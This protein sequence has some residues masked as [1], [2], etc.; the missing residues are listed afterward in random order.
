MS[1]II[2]GIDEAGRGPWAGPVIAACVILNKNIPGLT[3]SKKITAAKREKLFFEITANNIYSIAEA[4]VEEIDQLNILNATK[5]AISR[6]ISNLPEQADHYLIDGNMKFTNFSN[7]TSIV[8]GDL[9]EPSIS[10]ASIIAKVHRDNLMLQL[11][12]HYPE[13]NLASN[14][15]YGTKAHIEAVK[16][17]G[18]TAI[19]RKSFNFFKNDRFE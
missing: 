13:Y 16:K 12:E 15:G 19:H 5:L 4:S 18:L 14:K 2:A 9:K 8:K 7:Y 11:D 10:A 1:K 17:H 3:D 6:A